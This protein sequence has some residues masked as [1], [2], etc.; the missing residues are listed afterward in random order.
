MPFHSQ[1]KGWIALSGIVLAVIVVWG[2]VLPRLSDTE[3]VREREAFLK[4]NRIDP[5]AMFYTELECL[6][7]ERE[8][9][10]TP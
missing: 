1:A 9:D 10:P 4:K 5:A 6:E 7:P 2:F 8:A 3:L